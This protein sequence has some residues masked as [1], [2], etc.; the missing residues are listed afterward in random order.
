MIQAKDEMSKVF[1]DAWLA[2]PLS[3]GL[4][5]LYP[6]VADDPPDAGSWARVTVRHSNGGQA[7]LTGA[8]GKRRYRYVGFIAVQIFVERADGEVSI[9]ALAMIV[10][11]AFE[12]VTTSPGRVAFY[13]VRVNEVGQSGVWLQTNVLADFEYDEVR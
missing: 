11:N 1:R 6:D 3:A 7:T 5:V 4:P 9:D 10:K 12:G 13:R 8:L 2:D